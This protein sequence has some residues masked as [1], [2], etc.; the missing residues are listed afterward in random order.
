MVTEKWEQLS[1]H[2]RDDL[3][4]TSNL[5]P[6][7]MPSSAWQ[8][9]HIAKASVRE[10]TSN[11]ESGNPNFAF[12]TQPDYAT[13]LLKIFQGGLLFLTEWSSNSFACHSRSSSILFLLL[14]EP[15]ALQ[16]GL[17]CNPRGE[18]WL[19][20]AN[21]D[22]NSIPLACDYLERGRWYN[23]GQWNVRESTLP[24]FLSSSL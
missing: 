10:K 17:P 19:V 22:S 18:S 14:T 23:S 15:W 1:E 5:L 3:G 4:N 12:M 20:K 2:R 6:S 13:L 7:L 16:A 21:H 11:G 8:P 24:S 9:R